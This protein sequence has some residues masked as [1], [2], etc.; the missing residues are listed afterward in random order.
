MFCNHLSNLI[1]YVAQPFDA[2]FEGQ[3]TASIY[4]GTTGKINALGC[5]AS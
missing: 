1:P 5:S 2:T 3:N 4:L